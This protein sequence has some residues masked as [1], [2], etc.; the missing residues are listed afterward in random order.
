MGPDGGCAVGYRLAGFDV[1]GV[2]NRPQKNY[3]FPFVQG[4]ALEFLSLLIEGKGPAGYYLDDFD[5]IHASPPCQDHSSLRHRTAKRYDCHIAATRALLR[6]SGKP[7]V[8]ENVVGAPLLDPILLCG[9]AFDLRT[10]SA[11][12]GEVWLKRHR[13]FESNVKLTGN[14]CACKRDRKVIGVYGNGDGGGGRG[15]KGTM[16]DR[17]AVMGIWWMTRNELAQSIPPAY[18]R[19]LG[20]QLLAALT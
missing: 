12:R 15:W 2:D 5:A 3:P 13:L 11:E 19:E 17:R 1:V 18:T 10:D 4:D 6:K 9:A 8:I 16:A 20:R 14:G 7:W